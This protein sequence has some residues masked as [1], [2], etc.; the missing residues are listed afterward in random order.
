VPSTGHAG[1]QTGASI[2]PAC[3]NLMLQARALG[4]G[5]VMTTMHRRRRDRFH[6]I[7]GIP[8][9][10]DSAAIIPLGWPAASYGRNVRPPVESVVMRDRWE[11][12][13]E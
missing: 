4:L 7:L 2:Y 13:R 12:A 6:A 11:P 10:Y 9:G 5:T 8:D 1:F 3:Q